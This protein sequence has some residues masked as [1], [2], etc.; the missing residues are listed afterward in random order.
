MARL[1]TLSRRVREMESLGYFLARYR[2]AARA[3][4]TSRPNNEVLV[5]EWL[6]LDGLH[7]SCH[8]FLLEVLEK[9]KVQIHQLTLN[10]MV[11]LINFF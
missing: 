11:A 2:R 6:F 8:D 5:F 9:F 7:L 3:K 4:T 10:V 1:K